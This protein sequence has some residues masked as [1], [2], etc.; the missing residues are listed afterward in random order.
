MLASPGQTVH[1]VAAASLQLPI[2][3]LA[4]ATCDESL[5]WPALHAVQEVPPV[6]ASVSV[7]WPV[8]QTVQLVV[9]VESPNLPATQ[10]AHWTCD[11]LLNWP[12]EHAVQDDPPV[13]FSVLVTE[14][15]AQV[16]HDDTF[17]S[18]L[19]KPAAHSVHMLAPGLAP[20][21]VN[22]P[23]LQSS[24]ASCDELL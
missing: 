15:P 18:R 8:L 3:Q 24:Q 20:V 16:V 12:V 13:S 21:L 10:S 1:S 19:N 7:I 6:A 9:P 23:A 2:E 17:D 22:D 11:E 14:P 5:D 4:H